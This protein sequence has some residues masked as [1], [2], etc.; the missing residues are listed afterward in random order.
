[1]TGAAD[2]YYLAA[3]AGRGPLL[4][5]SADAGS[6]DGTVWA[7]AACGGMSF[8]LA[9]LIASTLADRA[10]GRPFRPTGLESIDRPQ[11]LAAAVKEFAS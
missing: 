10:L 11:P 4:A 3:S 5:A 6:G 8:K 1:M 9:P 2:G 7:Y